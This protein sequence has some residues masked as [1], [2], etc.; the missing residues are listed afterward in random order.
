M[1]GEARMIIGNVLK[2]K[3]EKADMIGA[4]ITY[5]PKSISHLAPSDKD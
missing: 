5:T 3:T 2:N 1:R 4:E